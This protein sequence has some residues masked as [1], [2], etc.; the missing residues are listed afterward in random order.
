MVYAFS[1]GSW[2][3]TCVKT[4]WSTVD[5]GVLWCCCACWRGPWSGP[6]WRNPSHTVCTR[7]P[8]CSGA[9]GPCAA[10]VQWERGTMHRRTRTAGSWTLPSIHSS[11]F[12]SPLLDQSG[13][14]AFL[15]LTDSKKLKQ[16]S[17][18]LLAALQADEEWMQWLNGGG[19]QEVDGFHYKVLGFSD[20]L[21]AAWF[22]RGQRLVWLGSGVGLCVAGGPLRLTEM[23]ESHQRKLKWLVC[24]MVLHSFVLIL[25]RQD[26]YKL[27]D[28]CM[29][30]VQIRGKRRKDRWVGGA[31]VG[32]QRTDIERQQAETSARSEQC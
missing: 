29:L 21:R 6:C 30:T 2:D 20:C 18:S 24:Q 3:C 19:W 27:D 14:R 16:T 11:D 28:L 32:G 4:S 1:C 22:P 23:G 8:V 17:N 9:Q 13:S 10:W 25:Q 15:S 31:G 7:G 12:S 5:T 26:G